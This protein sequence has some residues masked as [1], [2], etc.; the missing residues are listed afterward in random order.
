[1]SPSVPEKEKQQRREI[2]LLALAE[3]CSVTHACEHA[4]LSRQTV[5]RWRVEHPDFR[6]A[7]ETALAVGADRLE[8][9]AVRR[10]VEGTDKPVYQGGRQVGVIREYSDVLLIFLLKGAKPEKYRERVEQKTTLTGKDGGPISLQHLEELSD[11]ELL[12][13]VA[14]GGG[15]APA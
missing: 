8:D 1:M 14:R 2:F 10:A 7:W 5:Y 3:T 13:I 9:E 15:S 11:E 4:S 12:A 6:T